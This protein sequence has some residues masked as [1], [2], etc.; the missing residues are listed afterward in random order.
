MTIHYRAAR[1]RRRAVAAIDRAVQRPAGR[2]GRRRGGSREPAASRRRRTRASR[3]NALRGSSTAAPRSTS[4]TTTRMKTRLRSRGSIGSLAYASAPPPPR[5]RATTSCHR[6]RSTLFS[7][8]WPGCGGLAPL[9]ASQPASVLVCLRGQ[10]MDF[11]GIRPQLRD[12]GLDRLRRSAAPE[13]LR[14][15]IGFRRK[16]LLGLESPAQLARNGY[17]RDRSRT[18]ANPRSLRSGASGTRSACTPGRAYPHLW[19]KPGGHIPQRA[20]SWPL[21]QA[22][23]SPP[24][25][26]ASGTAAPAPERRLRACQP[27]LEN[28]SWR[29]YGPSQALRRFW[30]VWS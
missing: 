22:H 30:C 4:A 19:P 25:R 24:A 11:N 23:R 12:D 29:G 1:D 16:E 7:E 3:F 5:A 18:P 26:P 17:S 9:P 15:L 20:T 27:V 8:R 28:S 6:A 14:A 13:P 10:R 2:T 21:W